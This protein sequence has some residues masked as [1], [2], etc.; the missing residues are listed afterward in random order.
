LQK[1]YDNSYKNYFK[2][3][4]IYKSIEGEYGNNTMHY[5]LLCANTKTFNTDFREAIGIYERILKSYK[6]KFGNE[7][8]KL[9][10]VYHLL[11]PLYLKT[12]RT[13]AVFC[14][15]DEI[16]SNIESRVILLPYI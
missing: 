7:S 5:L 14:I 16:I 8:E 3:Y 2:C 9:M 10:V 12:G 15:I 13:E 6:E 1:K 11:L 4:E